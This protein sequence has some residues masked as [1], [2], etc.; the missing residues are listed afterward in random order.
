[1]RPFSIILLILSIPSF[2]AAESSSYLFSRTKGKA[3][4]PD[5]G[6]NLLGLARA[7]RFGEA[8]EGAF[9]IQEVEVAFLSDVDPYFRAAALLSLHP[10]GGEEGHEYGIEPEEI[11]LETSSIPVVSLKA[12]KFKAAI[13]RHNLLHT[14]AYPFI[15]AP[16]FQDALLGEEGLNDVG[17]SVAALVPM[18]WYTEFTLQG[19]RGQAEPLFESQRQGELAYV[20]HL[21]QL[22]EFSDALTLQL[23]WSGATG[24]SIGEENTKVHGADLTFKW[25]PTEGGKYQALSWSTE[26]LSRTKLAEAGEAVNPAG[27]STWLQYQFGQRWWIQGRLEYLRNP[28]VQELDEGGD[29][30]DIEAAP[31]ITIRKQSVLLGFFPS[32][33]SGFRVQYDHISGISESDEHRLALQWNV[34]IGAHPAH[35]Y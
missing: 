10:E 18:P 11:F 16:F 2:A 8:N 20:A 5:I 33:F 29:V 27:I 1:M 25:R 19:F 15:D 7:T 13:G 23:G 6:V 31:A 21:A 3:F 12:G 35:Q 34:S 17:L 9:S 28:S 30:S 32:E 26:Y 4:N 22:W 14:H 24:P